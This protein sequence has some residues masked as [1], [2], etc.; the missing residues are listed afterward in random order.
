MPQYKAGFLTKEVFDSLFELQKDEQYKYKILGLFESVS[1]FEVETLLSLKHPEFIPP[2]LAVANN[3]ISRGYPTICSHTVKE[4]FNDINIKYTAID[5]FEALH[6][7]DVSQPMPTLF[8]K[9]L[10][11]GFEKDFLTKIIPPDKRYLVQFFQHQRDLGTVIGVAGDER[12]VD[13]SF[14]PPYFKKVEKENIFKKRIDVKQRS[15]IE[16]I[17]IDGKR[18]H[19]ILIKDEIRDF[20]TGQFGKTHRITED[21]AKFDTEIL[22]E[23]LGDNEYIKVV[24]KLSAMAP[25]KLAELQ[26]NVLSPIAIA[27][28]Q[29]VINEY[30]I[31]N[32][33]EL[34]T[35]GKSIIS[36]AII[37]RDIQCGECA[38]KDLNELYSNLMSLENR[39]TYIPILET[40]VFSADDSRKPLI[41]ADEFDLII[42]I[43]VLWRKG[44]FATDEEFIH[45][46]NVIVIRSSHFTGDDCIDHVYCSQQVIYRDLTEETG[47]E[48]HIEIEN[49]LPHIEYFL[50]YIFCKNSFRPGQLPILNRALKNKSVIGLLPTGGG[51][52]LTYQL[53]ALLQPG[54]TIVIDPIRSLMIDQ[55][56]GLLKNGID[57][58][59]FIN[60]ILSKEQRKYVYNNILPKGKTQFLF[61]SPER[62]V[63]QDFRDAIS[64]AIR[65]GFPCSYC[66]I[67]EAHCVS[68]WG[69]D[70]RTP[71]LNI[72]KNAVE[73]CKTYGENDLP[74]FGLT[75]TASFDVLA[76]I[77]RE[78]QIKKDDGKAIIRYENTVRNEINYHIQQVPAGKT[79]QTRQ[80]LVNRLIESKNDANGLL[81]ENNNEKSYEGILRTAFDNYASNFEKG[82][83]VKKYIS[84]KLYGDE[85]KPGGILLKTGSDLPLRKNED[86]RYKYGVIVFCPHTGEGPLGV[87][88]YR[89]FLSDKLK[90]EKVGFFVGSNNGRDKESFEN[91]KLFSDNKNSVMVATKAFG[92]GIDKDNIRLTIHTNMASSIESFVQESGRAGRDGKHALSVVLY[93]DHTD[94]K[95]LD[96]F[97]AKS[98]KGADKERSVLWELRSGIIFPNTTNLKKLEEKLSTE[99][100]IELKLNLWDFDSFIYIN[101]EQGNVIGRINFFAKTPSK[102]IDIEIENKTMNV[103]SSFIPDFQIITSADLRAFLEQKIVDHETTVGIE[104]KLESIKV[105]DTFEFR[106][107]FNNRYYCKDDDGYNVTDILALNE[108]YKYFTGIQLAHGLIEKNLITNDDFYALFSRAIDENWSYTDFVKQLPLNDQKLKDLLLNDN[109]LKVRYYIPRNMAD[110]SKAVYRLTSIGI[111]DSYTIDYSG[112]Y[113]TLYA[114]KKEYDVYFDNFRDLVSRYTSIEDANKQREDCVND[115]EKSNPST[116]IGKCLEHL[117]N[118]IYSKIADKRQR[119]IDDMDNLCKEWVSSDT[120]ITNLDQSEKIKEFIYYYFNAKYSR[121][122]NQANIG[123]GKFISADMKKDVENNRNIDE[124]IWEYIEEIVEKDDNRGFIN[125]IKHLRG[126]TMRMLR[127]Y[128]KYPQFMI[129]KAYS[130][131]ILSVKVPQLRSE[132]DIELISGLV[133]WNN[134]EKGK[135]DLNKF[136]KRFKENLARHIKPLPID[137]FNDIEDELYSTINLKWMKN[138]NKEF[139][140]NYN[141]AITTGN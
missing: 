102:F 84:N 22:F 92:M 68:E 91:L 113:Y 108:H 45:L 66:V 101:D 128:E 100:S 120:T 34:H 87:Q 18:Y 31:A 24:D 13:F 48:N 141:N 11:S 3:I 8:T 20:E 93:G 110:T 47:N 131:Y 125:N 65:N 1:S 29:K 79:R 78:L 26:K 109:M 140:K 135:L 63:I 126:A 57:R 41:K 134:E 73:Y 138:F 28:I 19:S 15:A 136:I 88:N 103:V 25:N 80:S 42:D 55:Y 104:R 53:A 51:K 5:Y 111:I 54:I 59:D 118:F 97:F 122:G 74:I 69:H 38:I 61:C 17:E 94:R 36:V 12:R 107:P 139:L 123:G 117:T 106:V 32:Y 14:E 72:G 105:G 52:S 62:F 133:M 132:A 129:L 50:K 99:L 70:F 49:A 71:Y 7:V 90:Q 124:T 86:E 114:S 127:A 89:T 95:V 83:E 9:D 98:F 56:E 64:V 30:L 6:I 67:D 46:P 23:W 96:E 37:E 4:Y 112:K 85:K 40:K 43:A 60:S 130:L 44:I 21:R 16:I 115:Y 82:N 76:D 2:L 119:A 81:L 27:R 137:Y 33:S 77:E 39:D 116:V 35:E 121:K 10:E 58:C 75:A